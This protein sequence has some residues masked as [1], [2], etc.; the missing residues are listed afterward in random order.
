MLLRI[1][2][3]LLLFIYFLQPGFSVSSNGGDKNNT[4]MQLLAD[5]RPA[6]AEIYFRQAIE[7][8]NRVE[9][10]YNNLA[11]SLM[12]QKKYNEAITQLNKAVIIDP[13]YVKAISNLAVCYFYLSDYRKAYHYYRM[14]EKLNSDY[15]KSRFTREKIK[16]KTKDVENKDYD[17]KKINE[18]MDRMT[19][20]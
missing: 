14:A 18:I 4:G 19:I 2:W 11:V 17:E 20:N 7:E 5:N 1:I 9:Y 10:Y 8:N 12:H 13:D 3:L 15:V 16:E 6:E